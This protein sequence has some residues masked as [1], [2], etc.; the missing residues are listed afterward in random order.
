MKGKLAKCL[1]FFEIQNRLVDS[2]ACY[3]DGQPPMGDI[4]A[5]G[6]SPLS[7]GIKPHSS[8]KPPAPDPAIGQAALQNSEIARAQLELG[9]EQ[10]AW[11]RELWDQQAPM[12]NALLQSNVDSTNFNNQQA[13]DQWQQ[14]LS[15]FAPTERRVAEEA[16]TYDSPQEVARRTGLAAGTVQTQIDSQR[17]Q[18]SRD[19]GRM[20]L[21]P[22]SGRS[23]MARTEDANFATLAKAGA[24]NQ[25]RNNTKLLGLSLRQ[26][27]AQL[28][29][30]LPSTGIA[31]SDAALRGGNAAVGNM[32]AQQ[33]QRN[34]M[35]SGA[36]NANQSAMN[37]FNSSANILNN[38]YQNQLAAWNGRNSFMGGLIGTGVGAAVNIFSDKNKKKNI[39]PIDDEVALDGVV[40]GDDAVQGLKKIPI[41]KWSY[42]E[43]VAD[44]GEH[45]GPMAQDVN[46]Q[47]GDAAA[48]DGTSIDPVT[49]NGITM[50]ATKALAKKV[51]RLEKM[52]LKKMNRPT[53]PKSRSKGQMDS[54]GDDDAIEVEATEIKKDAPKNIPMLGLERL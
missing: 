43:G 18:M 53:E 41:S 40:S 2:G 9:R 11:E 10:L 27:A 29:R 12:Y 33:Q 19:M 4:R 25:E 31:A 5:R 45:I 16:L 28:G 47:F 50:A 44:G 46:K 30:N 20:G 3:Y 17:D 52:G 38:Q 1:V 22:T 34:N 23:A 37:G 36:L 21:S 54:Y 48:P 14:Y 42:K 13:R 51:E 24:I 49:M 7:I 15:V 8:P 39:R 26:Q 35:Y 6:Y 32:G